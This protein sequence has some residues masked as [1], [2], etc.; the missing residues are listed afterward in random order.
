MEDTE[1]DVIDV[2]YFKQVTLN[3]EIG[4]ICW[5][6]GADISPHLLYKNCL[7]TNET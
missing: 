5:K 6:N 7:K 3:H 2:N 1:Y 4:T